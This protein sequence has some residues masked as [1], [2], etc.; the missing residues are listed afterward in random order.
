MVSAADQQ[1]LEKNDLKGN[2]KSAYDYESFT[3]ASAR[4]GEGGLPRRSSPDAG[5]K[6]GA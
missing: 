6:A 2:H 1:R 4:A 3:K 5:A